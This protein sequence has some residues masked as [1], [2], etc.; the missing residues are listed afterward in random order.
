VSNLLDTVVHPTAALFPLLEGPAFEELV[1]DIKIRGQ[2]IPVVRHEGKLIDG[3]NRWRA[4]R[5]AGIEPVE[6]DWEPVPG[7]TVSE[8]ILST[9]TVRRHL[10]IDQV[11]MI[12]A[13]AAQAIKEERA[14]ARAKTQFKKGQS[15]NP[16]G[17][18][19]EQA[20]TESY[21]PAPVDTREKNARS[22]VGI[23]AAMAGGSHHKAAQAVALATAAET[24]PEAAAVVEQVKAGAVKLK[25]AVK[26]VKQA[27]P[28]KP[29]QKKTAL[30][31]FKAATKAVLD[32][33]PAASRNAYRDTLHKIIDDT[34]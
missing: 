10:T 24:S 23:V 29:A 9:N 22:T 5:V 19:K 18:A 13:Q 33:Q 28:R 21:P 7:V 25:D 12:G 15:G 32:E 20:D 17:K 4:C 30:D 3:R 14:A 26:K 34:I 27:K 11:N 6:I 31:K 1:E 2:L 16:T 8:W